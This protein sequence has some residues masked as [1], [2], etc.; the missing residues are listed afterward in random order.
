MQMRNPVLTKM[1][2]AKGGLLDQSWLPGLLT[3]ILIL[4][5]AIFAVS[6]RYH[7]NLVQYAEIFLQRAKKAFLA[8]FGLTTSFKKSP[9]RSVVGQF[10]GLRLAFPIGLCEPTLVKVP[11]SFLY[12]QEFTSLVA[13]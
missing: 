2:R 5:I 9:Y 7:E 3:V 1:R 12:V 11:L 8:S 4:L 6:L 13:K 10:V